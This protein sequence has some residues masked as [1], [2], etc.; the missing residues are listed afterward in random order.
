MCR[1]AR[2]LPSSRFF[3]FARAFLQTAGDKSASRRLLGGVLVQGR[4]SVHAPACCT[5]IF[6]ATGHLQLHDSYC[7]VFIG[8]LRQKP[9]P[10]QPAPLLHLQTSE[11]LDF[12]TGLDF[13][14]AS[15]GWERHIE[16][17]SPSSSGPQC[18]LDTLFS[19]F[20]SACFRLSSGVRAA[21]LRSSSPIGGFWLRSAGGWGSKGSWGQECVGASLPVQTAW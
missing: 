20:S 7:R 11:R 16:I 4:A 8:S 9:D 21:R 10:L 17:T 14:Y 12:R 1:I 19:L 2:Y 13:L 5:E 6:G 18:R 15:S 3:F